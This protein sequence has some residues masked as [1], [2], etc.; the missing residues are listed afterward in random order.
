MSPPLLVSTQN[1]DKLREISLLF[2]QY[3]E[4]K[5]PSPDDPDV[6]ETGETLYENALLKAK[7][8]YDRYHIPAIADD[9][10]LEVDALEGRPGVFSS[11]YA[12]ESASYADNVRLLLKELEGVPREQRRARFRTVIAYVNGA[13]TERFD[14]VLE[15]WILESPRGAKGFGYDPVFVPDQGSMSL[16]EMETD[17]KNLISHR[18]K[19]LRSFLEWWKRENMTNLAAGQ[20]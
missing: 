3:A 7:A 8:G 15:G 13:R 1:R 14:G 2:G 18:G 5:T 9:T 17:A 12:G 20:R 19:A 10:G 11:R 6:E 4:I 16:A